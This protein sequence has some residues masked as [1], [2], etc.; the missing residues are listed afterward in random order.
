MWLFESWP[1]GESD[2]AIV[3]RDLAMSSRTLHRRLAAEGFSN[4]ELLDR[5]RRETAETCLA[6][7]SLSIAEVA[8]LTGYSE[9]AAFQRAFRRWTGTTPRCFGRPPD[10]RC[11]TLP[12]E[13]LS[14]E[15][16]HLRL[17]TAVLHRLAFDPRQRHREPPAAV[18]PER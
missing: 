4:H 18:Q 3:A 5:L 11:P 15:C 12:I 9:P 16:L 17:K 13:R 10:E 8:Y 6:D 1:K 2:I 14:Q 7:A